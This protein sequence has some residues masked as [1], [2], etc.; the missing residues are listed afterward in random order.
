MQLTDFWFN[1]INL[2]FV[3]FIFVSNF[4]GFRSAKVLLLDLWSAAL[5]VEP[6]SLIKSSRLLST[7]TTWHQIWKSITICKKMTLYIL[8]SPNFCYLR[9]TEGKL[10]LRPISVNAQRSK[11]PLTIT[12]NTQEGTEKKLF[13][14]FYFTPS[15]AEKPTKTYEVT[16]CERI[17]RKEKET[18]LIRET[19]ISNL[20]MDN[21][22]WRCQIYW[23]YRSR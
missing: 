15:K 19:E 20:S 17:W 14:F 10:S 9:S 7:H 2:H 21:F 8:I 23:F 12:Q 5:V 6:S 13:L 16:E 3:V 22:S 18:L 11:P 4:S 1:V